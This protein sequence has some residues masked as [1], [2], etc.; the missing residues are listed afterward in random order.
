MEIW[1]K[2]P[3]FNF[4]Y[5]ISNQGRLRSLHKIII[6]SDG[7]KYTR[8]PKVLKQDNNHDGYSRG[9]ISLN[10]TMIPYKIHRLVAEMFIPNKESKE[11]VNHINGIKSDNRVCN[12]EWATREEQ[13]T[14]ALKNGLVSKLKGSEIGNSILKDYQVKEIRKKFTPR[15]YTRK[16]LSIEYG[17][18]EATIKDII[19]ERTW[20]HLL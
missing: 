19:C 16:M 8:K 15:V 5:E 11:T 3:K 20:K 10:G 6:K 9:A 17:V 13:K 4:E 14:H 12:L 18:S 7:K 2:I 1:K